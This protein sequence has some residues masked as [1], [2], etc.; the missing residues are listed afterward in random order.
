MWM[1]WVVNVYENATAKYWTQIHFPLFCFCT[2][3]CRQAFTYLVDMFRRTFHLVETCQEAMKM[4]GLL[5]KMLCFLKCVWLWLFPSSW[6]VYHVNNHQRWIAEAVAIRK[7]G[8]KRRNRDG[9]IHASSSTTRTYVRTCEAKQQGAWS[10][11]QKR[12]V[13]T[14]LVNNTCDMSLPR[15]VFSRNYETE[16]VGF[17]LVLWFPPTV[18]KCTLG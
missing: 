1:L 9:G 10:S 13:W 17:L 18:Q 5:Q 8:P 12:R 2:E 14:H 6:C 16:D 3:C 11:C 4:N 15:C 7:G